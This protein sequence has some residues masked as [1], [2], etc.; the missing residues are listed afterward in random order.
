[1]STPVFS[2]NGS[3]QLLIPQQGEPDY[4][5]KKRIELWQFLHLNPKEQEI[6]S[7]MGKNGEFPPIGAPIPQAWRFSLVKL[8]DTPQR[9]VAGV[10]L[11]HH[12]QNKPC[13]ILWLYQGLEIS[14]NA[15]MIHVLGHS[16]IQPAAMVSIVLVEPSVPLPIIEIALVDICNPGFASTVVIIPSG[17]SNTTLLVEPPTLPGNKAFLLHARVI[18]EDEEEEE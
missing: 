12:P 16:L 10:M 17:T 13:P 6:L 5:G 18:D 2:S 9:I 7:K 1:M 15:Q 14:I 4:A 3:Q 8:V 11:Y